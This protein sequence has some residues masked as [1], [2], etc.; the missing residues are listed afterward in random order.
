MADIGTGFVNLIFTLNPTAPCSTQIIETFKLNIDPLAT[1]DFTDDG[2]F[3]EGID[4]P[5]TATF[6][7]HDPSTINWTIVSGTGTLT[8]GNTASPTYEPGADSDTVV[9]QISVD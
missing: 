6:T 3:C 2:F 1:I 9:I 8:D 7:N 5:L 4:K